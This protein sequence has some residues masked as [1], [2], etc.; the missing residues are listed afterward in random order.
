MSNSLNENGLTINT[1]SETVTS[2]TTLWQNI[3]GS[4]IIL[5]SNTADGQ[6][7]NNLAQQIRDLSELILAVYNSFDPDN[8][9]GSVL[10]QRVAINGIQRQGGTFTQQQIDI[11]VD[12][13]ITLEG[14]DSNYNDVNGVGYT[15]ADNSGNQ[16]ILAETTSLT[17]GT[18][19]LLFR[20]QTL[21]PVQTL[22]NTITNPVTVIVGVTN[23]NNTTSQLE[24]GVAEET[25]VALRL[26]RQKS[27]ANNSSTYLNG[28]QGTLANLDGVTDVIVYEND[29]SVTDSNNI[30]D[31][32]IWAIVEGGSNVDI[33][34][35]IAK[36]KAP[37]CGT[38]GSDYYN[39][40]LPNNTIKPFYF[41]RPTAANLYIK[42]DIQSLRSGQVFNLSDIKSYI[43]N[44]KTYTIG[45]SAETAN[46]TEIAL[47][48]INATSLY[49]VPLNLQISSNN[50]T[51]VSFLNT[52]TLDKK[53]VTSSA[54]I[55]ITVL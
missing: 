14:L 20:S 27:T 42:F 3:F 37:G 50:S 47:N 44:N 55:S 30:P 31:H 52:S 53:W 54:N 33:A 51:W 49:G 7:I 38:Y 21:G 34:N 11:T 46:L 23:I 25:D 5:T 10:D 1:L 28:L 12:R 15:V 18:H 41:S 26:R 13:S 6:L 2:L 4:D 19:T 22:P 35:T 45:E 16:F 24:L 40:V 36:K 48:A 32:S 8:A 9:F 17:T 43:V 39:V 29:T